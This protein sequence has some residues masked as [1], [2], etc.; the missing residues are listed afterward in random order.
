MSLTRIIQDKIKTKEVILGYNRVMKQ[1]KTGKIKMIVFAKNL[2][3]NK[4]Q[5]IIYNANLAKVE[6]KEF[7]GDNVNLGLTCGKPFSVSV[8]AIKERDKK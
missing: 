4:K 7:D 8:L 5:E 1:L 2:P 3:E 6:V